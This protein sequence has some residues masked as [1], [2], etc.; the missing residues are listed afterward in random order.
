MKLRIRYA[1]D[2]RER[3]NTC[4]LVSDVELGD[5]GASLADLK[6]AIAGSSET[7][8]EVA[9]ALGNSPLEP[10]H[11]QTDEETSL[12]SLGVVKNDIVWVTSLPAL[13]GLERADGGHVEEMRPCRVGFHLPDSVC[14][15]TGRDSSIVRMIAIEAMESI[16]FDRT[17]TPHVETVVFTFSFEDDPTNSVRV[18][19]SPSI[20]ACSCMLVGEITKESSRSDVARLF[21][22]QGMRTLDD[23]LSLFNRIVD[24]FCVPLVKACCLELGVECP[25]ETLTSLP[26]EII[27]MIVERLPG[28][29]APRSLGLVCKWLA[30]I[31]FD[32][33][34]V[35]YERQL[36][37]RQRSVIRSGTMRQP[38][39]VGLR[40]YP[41]PVGGGMGRHIIGGA[42]DM[43]PGGGFV[44]LPPRGPTRSSQHW[45]L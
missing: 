4:R 7:A 39:S 12:K 27:E 3:A 19:V 32:R 41:N 45:R 44:G 34:G 16:G 14:S 11:G 29:E 33:S 6:A 8:R 40:S 24:G 20:M 26:R 35:F 10:P 36:T 23:R 21:R 22:Y 37:L 28:S 15:A 31:V 30:A 38:P 2:V 13:S 25:L 1:T 5:Q 43:M 17:V 18:S 9:L 42:Y